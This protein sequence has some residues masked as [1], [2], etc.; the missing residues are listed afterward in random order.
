VNHQNGRKNHKFDISSQGESESGQEKNGGRRKKKGDQQG[1]D[2]W[3]RVYRSKSKKK[4]KKEEVPKNRNKGRKGCTPKPFRF[5]GGKKD[6]T[7]GGDGGKGTG[8]KL[9]EVAGSKKGKGGKGEGRQK[10]GRPKNL[11]VSKSLAERGKGRQW[12]TSTPGVKNRG[13]KGGKK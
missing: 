10:K 5:G 4:K 3:T 9:R 12:G 7:V 11:L 6:A 1:D 8:K 2:P 13:R